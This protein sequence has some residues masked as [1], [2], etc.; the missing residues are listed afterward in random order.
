MRLDFERH[1]SAAVA[2]LEG[3][4]DLANA[5]ALRARLVESTPQDADCLVVDLGRVG[6]IDSAGV[7]LLFRLRTDLAGRAEVIVVAPP[8]SRAHRILGL[9]ALG[10]FAQVRDSVGEALESCAPR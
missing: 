8:S 4:I 6:Y 2:Y 7:E 9:V 1:D 3:E 5:D 10:E